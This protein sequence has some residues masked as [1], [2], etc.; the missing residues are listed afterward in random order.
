MKTIKKGTT[1]C[2]NKIE[3][4]FRNPH[5][6]GQLSF[7]TLCDLCFTDMVLCNNIQNIDDYSIYDNMKY[8]RGEDEDDDELPEV[9]QFYIVQPDNLYFEQ[10]KDNFVMTYSD[11]LDVYILCVTHFGTSWRYIGTGV[12]IEE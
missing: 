6:Y 8:E 9:Y 2:K 3:A 7:S 11:V 12:K 5:L 4:D 10:Y 1:H